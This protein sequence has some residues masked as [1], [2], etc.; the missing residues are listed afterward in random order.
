MFFLFIVLFLDILNHCYKKKPYKFSNF[1]KDFLCIIK[2]SLTYIYI[3]IYIL[4]ISLEYR[5]MQISKFLVLSGTIL[6][7]C[8]VRNTC[9]TDVLIHHPKERLWT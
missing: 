2:S 1:P 4:D 5:R 9:R 7:L 8:F 3:Y 6:Y